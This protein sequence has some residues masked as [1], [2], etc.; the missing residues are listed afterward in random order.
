MK[1][2]FT[3]RTEGQDSECTADSLPALAMEV[4]I[5]LSEGSFLLKYRSP[6][7]GSI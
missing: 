1:G 4:G 2:E 3:E 6:G 5:Q 7:L